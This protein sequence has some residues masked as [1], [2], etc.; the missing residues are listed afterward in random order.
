MYQVLSARGD[1]LIY[2]YTARL[3]RFNRVKVKSLVEYNT[4]NAFNSRDR[5]IGKPYLEVAIRDID[6]SYIKRSTLGFI[7]GNGV[8]GCKRKLRTAVVGG[9]LYKVTY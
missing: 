7:N 3:R 8:G 1:G 9:A 4:F 5:Y 6:Y 2:G